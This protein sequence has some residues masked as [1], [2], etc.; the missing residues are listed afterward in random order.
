MR[1][2]VT[3]LQ[4]LPRS[5]LQIPTTFSSCLPEESISILLKIDDSFRFVSG[6]I[7]EI[8]YEAISKR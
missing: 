2:D 7:I 6:D 4:P 5:R 8:L 3:E 1:E